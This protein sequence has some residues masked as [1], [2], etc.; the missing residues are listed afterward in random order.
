MRH[1][2]RTALLGVSLTALAT[3]AGAAEYKMTVNKDRLIN[4]DKEPQ[5]WLMMNGDYGSTRYSRLGQINRDNVKN[6]RMVWAL[7]LRG[8]QDVGQNGPENEVNPLIDNGFM[9]TSDGWG[10]VYKIDVRSGDHGE[11][12]WIADPGVKHEGNIP[13]SRGIALW[14]DL[15]INNL[16][17]GR[18]IAINRDS[19]EIVWDKQVAKANEFGTKERMNSAPI[20]AEGKVIVANGAGDGGTRGWLAGLDARTGN[21]LWRWYAIPKPGEPGS[22]TWKDKNNAWKTGGG[23]IWQTGSYDAET[24]LTIWGTGN[25]VPQYDPQSRPGDNLYTDSAVALNIDTGK[26]AWYFQYTPNDSWDYDEIGVH[27]LYDT[28]INGQMRKVV[29]HFGR[30]GFFYSLDRT[31]GRFLKGAQYVNDLNWT[32]GIDPETGKP[33]EYNPK[34]D[35]QIYNP[36][37]RAMRGDPEKKACP[38]WHGGVAHQPTA[39]N[40]V[41]H[42]AYG[43]GVEGCFTQNGATTKFLSENGGIDRKGS[44]KHTINSDLYYGSITAFDTINHKVIAKALTDIEIRSGAT[45]TAGGLVFTALQDGWVVAYNDETLEELWRFNVGTALKGAP[46]TYSVGT[47]QYLAVQTSGRHLHPVKYDNFQDSSYLFVFALN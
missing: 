25:P 41:K 31:N 27:M 5:N 6:L 14:E 11:F 34:L 20:T 47:K 8:M 44:E 45:V 23:G 40:P 28:I 13:R 7:S 18:V 30:N 32:K 38:T 36:V 10:T 24:K 33:V 29:G 19:G 21:E 9:Y 4:S 17:D 2:I 35:V 12:V 37:A 16:P 26:L 22:E 3:A 39:Y 15:V 46:V 1:C 43:V 42:I